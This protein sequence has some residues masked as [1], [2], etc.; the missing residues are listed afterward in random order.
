MSSLNGTSAPSFLDG[1][2]VEVTGT[3]YGGAPYHARG[4]TQ[5]SYIGA[6]WVDFYPNADFAPNSQVCVRTTYQGETGDPACE[7]IYP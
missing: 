5:E 1:V 4:Q 2:T 7:T 6:A 3:L